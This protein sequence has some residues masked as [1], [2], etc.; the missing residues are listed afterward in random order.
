MTN[1]TII[2]PICYLIADVHNLL[3]L[4]TDGV[5]EDETPAI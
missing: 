4:V 5:R 1:V 2:C 3:P